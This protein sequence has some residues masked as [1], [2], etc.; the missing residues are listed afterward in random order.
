MSVPVTVGRDYCHNKLLS[1]QRKKKGSFNRL[2]QHWSAHLSFVVILVC[3]E[4]GSQ[5]IHQVGL[6]LRELHLPLPPS[7]Y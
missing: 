5:Y 6:K 3:L 1:A 4:T 2:V 7:G